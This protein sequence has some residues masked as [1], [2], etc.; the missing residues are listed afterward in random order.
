[1]VDGTRAALGYVVT[2]I[3]VVADAPHRSTEALVRWLH[4]EYGLVPPG[5]FVGLA[6]QTDLIGPITESVLR[7][8][9]SFLA[10]RGTPEVNLA[11]NVY[12]MMHHRNTRRRI[13]ALLAR[14]G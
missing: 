6:E 13:V 14:R 9:T 2:P 10:A 5:E 1:M 4:P 11:V 3:F 8:S 12:P 7:T